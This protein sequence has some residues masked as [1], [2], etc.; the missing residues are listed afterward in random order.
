MIKYGYERKENIRIIIIVKSIFLVPLLPPRSLRHHLKTV[1]RQ[2]TGFIHR[3]KYKV[4]FNFYVE[5]PLFYTL[6]CYT[7]FDHIYY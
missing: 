7:N 3:K 6:A 2:C 4:G 5:P 1:N